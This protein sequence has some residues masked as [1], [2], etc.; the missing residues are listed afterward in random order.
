MHSL[1]FLVYDGNDNDGADKM[2]LLNRLMT[3]ERY[4][5]DLEFTQKQ[6]LI[7]WFNDDDGD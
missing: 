2:D 3:I 6:G 1:R 4:W 7:K 5:K